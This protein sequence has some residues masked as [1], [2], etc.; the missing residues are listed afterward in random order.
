[1][2]AAVRAHVEYGTMARWLLNGQ[3]TNG[4]P[5]RSMQDL[6]QRRWF[7]AEESLK[8]LA[9]R[10]KS[11]DTG[12]PVGPIKISRMF[13]DRSEELSYLPIAVASNYVKVPRTTLSRWL[14]D[15]DLR[16]HYR[17]AAV[18]DPL[19]DRLYISSRWVRHVRSHGL[20]E[21]P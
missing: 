17:M 7:I 19:N 3:T 16:K 14:D 13:D 10:F 6:E 12:L 9:E 18:R 1:M 5:L 11:L 2:N 20:P 4:V 15:P 21:R 8:M